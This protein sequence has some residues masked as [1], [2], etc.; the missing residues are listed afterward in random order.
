MSLKVNNITLATVTCIIFV[1]TY[2]HSLTLRFDIGRLYRDE[3][4][5]FELINILCVIHGTIQMG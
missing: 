4:L 5:C 2:F 1:I 3:K